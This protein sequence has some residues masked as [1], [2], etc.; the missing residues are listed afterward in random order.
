M[1]TGTT[2]YRDPEEMHVT[3]RKA[4]AA[5][6][7]GMLVKLDSTEGQVVKTTAITD[8]P[9][10][11]ALNTVG[12]GE[13]CRIQTGG[14]VKVLISAA[15]SLGAQVMPDS[16]TAGSAITS[17]G[18]TAVSCGIAESQGDTAGQFIRVRFMF[19]LKG[20]PNA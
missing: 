7:A 1:T 10:G 15:V 18:A 5:I 16:G 6:S 14:V 8:S 13:E 11:V 17:S 3:T 19:N 9:I 4:G 2:A 12:S 20:P